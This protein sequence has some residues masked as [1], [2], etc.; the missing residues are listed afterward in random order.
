ME[1]NELLD[2]FSKLDIDSQK[3]EIDNKLKEMLAMLNR[4]NN[5]ELVLGSYHDESNMQ[6]TRT[7][8]LILSI[9]NEIAKILEKTL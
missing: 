4:L 2:A 3:N 6:L 1:L 8:S 9:E 5:N 7:Y